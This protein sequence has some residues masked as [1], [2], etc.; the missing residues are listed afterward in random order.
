MRRLLLPLIPLLVFGSLAATPPEETPPSQPQDPAIRFMLA[1]TL[2]T[3]VHEMAHALIA[4]L[5]VPLLGREEDAADRIAT[6]ALLHGSAD[7]DI[8]NRIEEIEFVIAAAEA[9][10][11]E[12]ELERL[13]Q[14]AAPYWDSHSLDIQRFYN[15]VCLLYGSDPDK[16]EDLAEKLE[17]PAQRAL[18]CIDYEH[19]QA[20]SAVAQFIGDHSTMREGA[21][22]RGEIK[23]T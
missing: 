19:E 9:W 20:R 12:W 6:I 18:E 17:L 5:D 2:W 22:R 1:N 10:R 15:I 21:V 3:L 23:I 16:Y 11:V 4:E 14:S 13:H 8:P 7:H